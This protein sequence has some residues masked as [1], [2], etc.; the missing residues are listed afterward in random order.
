[1]GVQKPFEKKQEASLIFGARVA[2]AAAGGDGTW[3]A[4]HTHLKGADAIGSP[5]FDGGSRSPFPAAGAGGPITC[6]PAFANPGAY[7]SSIS[8]LSCTCNINSSSSGGSQHL[9]TCFR[10]NRK[11]CVGKLWGRHMIHYMHA[12]YLV[13]GYMAHN[14]QD[15]RFSYIGLFGL[16]VVLRAR[17]NTQHTIQRNPCASVYFRHVNI[18]L[19]TTEYTKN[20]K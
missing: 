6:P 4:L 3:A 15:F 7:S 12:E 16:G 17:R 9:L 18:A 14:F 2:A 19:H 10:W 8:I 20:R 5:S 1:M 11:V 13:C